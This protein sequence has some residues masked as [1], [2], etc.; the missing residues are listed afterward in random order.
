[1]TDVS[2]CVYLV[3]NSVNGKTYVGK[4][5]FDVGVRMKSHL[6]AA[7]KGSKYAFH[8]AIRKYGI[9]AFRIEAVEICESEESALEAEMYWVEWY[10]SFGPL[11]YNMTAGGRGNIGHKHTDE[12]RAK[13]RS[14]LV[15]HK[16][17]AEAHR[18]SLEVRRC[19]FSEPAKARM[20]AAQKERR[21]REKESGGSPLAGIKLSDEKKLRMSEAQRDS[22]ARRKLRE[23]VSQ[24]T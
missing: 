21:K 16:P 6:R 23:H 24:N 18:R 3:E 2:P 22:R 13:M 4:T 19:G 5:K 17:C 8:R 20:A 12:S 9:D 1:M 10:Q 7:S 15:G 11:G 14:A